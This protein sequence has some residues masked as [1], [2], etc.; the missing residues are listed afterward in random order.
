MRG[1]PGNSRH[2]ECASSPTPMWTF[3]IAGVCVHE[4]M[5]NS[6]LPGGAP[7]PAADRTADI[8]RDDTDCN[9]EVIEVNVVPCP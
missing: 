2:H 6:Q 8:Q 5:Q 7:R 3:A 4:T 9:A 1:Q